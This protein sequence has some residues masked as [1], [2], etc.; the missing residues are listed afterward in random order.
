MNGIA[1]D[2]HGS[3]P[4]GSVVQVIEEPGRFSED[5]ERLNR[6][7][8][9]LAVFQNCEDQEIAAVQNEHGNCY[10]I[11]ARLLKPSTTASVERLH[12]IRNA[13]TAINSQIEIYNV[14][15]DCSAAMR[16]TV[17]AMIDA[18]YHR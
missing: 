13:C 11:L 16:A 12:N 14:S 3:P 8:E 9:V 1:W 7:F 15:I 2:G 6:D 4:L 5:D 17:E 18:G 10:C